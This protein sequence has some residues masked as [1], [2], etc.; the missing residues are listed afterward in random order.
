MR[1][2]RHAASALPAPLH[3]DADLVGHPVEGAL[4]EMAEEFGGVLL[5]WNNVGRVLAEVEGRDLALRQGLLK[6]LALEVG[7]LGMSHR[8]YKKVRKIILDDR[9][10]KDFLK[11]KSEHAFEN[12]E[13]SK[14]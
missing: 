2:C 12:L 11:L 9:T 8:S 14:I 3:V 10:I 4:G 7:L 5:A 6:P 1:A 13:V